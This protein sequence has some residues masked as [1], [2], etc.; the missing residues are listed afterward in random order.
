M[1]KLIL[2]TAFIML[3][4]TSCETSPPSADQIDQHKQEILQSQGVA[5]AGMPN[6]D[7]FTELKL[8]NL[9]YSLRDNPALINYCYLQAEMT[10]KLIY[11]G[12]C[13]G[14]PIPYSTQRSN[15]SK[16]IDAYQAGG[17]Y[18]RISFPQSEPNGLFM[19]ASA[20]GT[21]VVMIDPTG[22]PKVCYFEPKVTVLPFK[23]EM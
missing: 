23:I 19:P 1:K 14:Y 22:Q 7:K 3:F 11:I 10:G 12:K 13:T 6:I 20:D 16:L 17:G 4:I 2:F 5:Q 18:S 8:V 15:P 9:I 21:W